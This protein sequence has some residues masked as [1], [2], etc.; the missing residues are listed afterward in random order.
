MSEKNQTITTVVTEFFIVGFPG[1]QPEYYNL[2]A[3]VFLSIY[4]AVLVGNSVFMVL[5]AIETSIRKP[6]Y[7][8]MLN[9]AVSDVG[10]CTVALPK[11]I[12]RY[13]FNN[14]SISFQLCLIQRLFIHY[15]GTLNSLIMMIMALD[16]Y[17]AICFPLRYPVLM[18]NR[19]MGLLSGLSW[20]S[21]LICPSISSLLTA[22]MPFCG[23]NLINNCFCDTLSMNNL[24][25]TDTRAVYQVQFSMA[26]FVL[27]A[28]FSFII[29]SYGSIVVTVIRTLNSQG[30]LKAFSTC[31]T[32]LCIISLYYAPRFFVYAAPNIPNL[33]MT[34]D[35]RLAISMFYSLMPPLVNPLI[36]C[37]RTKEIQQLFGKWCS[38][39]NIMSQKVSVVFFPK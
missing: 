4:V 8:I 30:R 33:K 32:Q 37:F 28:P 16:R 6:M 13:W 39:K 3:A 35:Q 38:R 21:A 26:M 10:F 7:I 9:L 2:M 5:F 1:L 31:A 11:L 15:F 12:S 29:F 27:L 36:Y 24:A 23:P 17:L 25:C 19:I 14:G 22:M 20:A 18:T 34:M